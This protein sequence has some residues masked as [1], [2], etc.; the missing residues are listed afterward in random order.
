MVKFI[1]ALALALAGLAAAAPALD[2]AAVK[3][4]NSYPKYKKAEDYE[5]VNSKEK[6]TNSYPKYGK[7]EDYE[8]VNSNEKRTNSYPKYG[9]AEDYEEVNGK[10]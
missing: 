10:E 3:R 5:A 4:T 6:R 9:K 8:A 2:H 1:A 7:A